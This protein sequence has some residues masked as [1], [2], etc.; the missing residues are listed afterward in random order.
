MEPTFLSVYD[1]NIL[2]YLMEQT[3]LSVNYA[4]ILLYLME[5][6]FLSVNYANILL[7]L[8]E[9]TFLS[10][11]YSHHCA[12]F[13]GS[14]SSLFSVYHCSTYWN[15][16][17]Y[18]L[19]TV[20]ILLYLLEL[21]FFSAFWS[22]HLFEYWGQRSCLFPIANNIPLSLPEPAFLS[23]YGSHATFLCDFLVLLPQGKKGRSCQV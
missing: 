16:H 21:I 11:N 5:Q 3:F 7:Y 17:S 6:T 23:V 19:T 4:N 20:T 1:A 18:L 10:V 14:N 8:M 13:T 22:Q 2:L 12:L 9:Q 15:Q